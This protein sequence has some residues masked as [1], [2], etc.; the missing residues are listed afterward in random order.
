MINENF[1]EA[2]KAYKEIIYDLF[3]P[4]KYGSHIIDLK[5]EDLPL[6]NTKINFIKGDWLSNIDTRNVIL[7]SNRLYNIELNFRIP[8][9][10]PDKIKSEILHEL[11]HAFD[12]YTKYKLNQPLTID[13]VIS[14]SL[15][16]TKIQNNTPLKIF[17]NVIYLSLSSELR[18]RTEQTYQDLKKFHTINK[19]FLKRELN[20]TSAWRD[21]S[22]LKKDS[23][24]RTFNFLMKNLGEIN[25]I[26]MINDFNLTILKDVNNSGCK[27]PNE[28]SFLIN[29]VNNLGDLKKY[30]DNWFSIINDN[31]TSHENDLLEVIEDVIKDIKPYTEAFSKNYKP[32]NIKLYEDYI[33]GTLE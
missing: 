16:K 1:C 31:I 12:F 27:I 17:R 15:S 19:S 26:K 14:I 11:N 30:F 20:N 13:M 18:S 21:L 25:T 6:F 8:V 28:Y 23:S 10:D 3:K 5:N 33:N 4:D 9:N 24:I 32:I 7:K 29:P 2:N 22:F